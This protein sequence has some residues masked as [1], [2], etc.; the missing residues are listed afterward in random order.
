MNGLLSVSIYIDAEQPKK[1]HHFPKN[2]SKFI[3]IGDIAIK[4]P[5]LHGQQL[6]SVKN[7]TFNIY[8]RV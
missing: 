7:V 3:K 6:S 8:P 1:L 4:R 5:V 2:S